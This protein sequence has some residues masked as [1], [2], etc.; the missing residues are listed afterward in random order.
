MLLPWGKTSVIGHLIDQWRRLR[1]EQ[2]AAVCAARDELIARELDRLR[3][4][5]QDRIFNPAPA[6]GMFSSVLCAARW[7]DWK[8]AL[9]H[10]AIVLG[11]QPHVRQATLGTLLDFASTHAEKICQPTRGGRRRH[12]VLLP[13][14]AFERL[15][16]ATEGT[17]KEFLSTRSEQLAQA[18]IDDPALDLDI[19]QPEDYRR[20]LQLFEPA[21]ER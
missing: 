21:P 20:A 2:I 4:P 7:P 15:K 16:E 3:F 12:P 13:R 6:T 5:A 11:D 1:A 14:A 8:P 17:L 10:W 19:D 18:E 9:T